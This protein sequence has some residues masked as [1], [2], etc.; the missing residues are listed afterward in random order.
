MKV[1]SLSLHVAIYIVPSRET[2]SIGAKSMRPVD[3]ELLFVISDDII[4]L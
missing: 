3:F 1:R 2:Y 4:V